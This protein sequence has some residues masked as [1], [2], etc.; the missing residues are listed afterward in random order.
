M[1]LATDGNLI[2]VTESEMFS[3]NIAVHIE[4]HDAIYSKARRFSQL[5]RKLSVAYKL[6]EKYSKFMN[7][8]IFD[9]S[10]IHSG[11]W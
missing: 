9:S 2:V 4:R 8:R 6:L 11:E 5:N 3:V 10:P 7:N 1:S